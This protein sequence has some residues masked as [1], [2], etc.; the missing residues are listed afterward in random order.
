VRAKL[1]VL[2]ACRRVLRPGGRIAFFTIY[3]AEGLS[4]KDYR[5][6]IRSRPPGLGTFR[7][8]HRELLAS[9]GFVAVAETDTSAEFLR[10]ARGWLEGRERNSSEMRAIE[11]DIDFSANQSERRRTVKAIKEGVLRRSLFVA[12]APFT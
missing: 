9:A 10:V 3:P 7:R 4:E 1:S 8:D 12:T 6:V 2:R 11:G 5:R